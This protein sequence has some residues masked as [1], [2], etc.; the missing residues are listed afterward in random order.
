MEEAG[1]RD[2]DG[3][4]YRELADGSRFEFRIDVRISQVAICELVA[5]H[6]KAVGVKTNLFPVLRD[7]LEPRRRYLEAFFLEGEPHDLGDVGIVIDH[8]D[9]L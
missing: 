5:E 2:S 3:D 6:W 1:I 4:G 7:I 9:S 8:Q